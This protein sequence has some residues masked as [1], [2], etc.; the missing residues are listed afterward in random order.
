MIHPIILSGGS[1]TRLWPASRK[2]YPKQFAPL[3]G[4]ESLYQITLR[5]LSGPEFAR[6]VVMTNVE[7]R[8]LASQQAHEIGLSDAH[9]AIEPA[10]RDTAPAILAAALIVEQQSGR[11][12]TALVAPSDH[13]IGDVAAFNAAVEKGRDAAAE[14][15][16]VTFGVTPD[17]PETGYGYLE[18]AA[19][20]GPS[21]IAVPLSAFREK[22]DAETAAKMIA[23]GNCLWNSGMFLFRV[24][25]VLDAF[26]AYAPDL[27][28]PVRAAV[29]GG[30]EDLSF[31][32]LAEAPFAEARD[33]AFDVAIMEKA[34]TA[35]AVPLSSAWS[36]LGAWDAL[37]TS[38]EHD[39]AGNATLGPTT[40]LDCERSYLRSEESNVH[41]VGLGL[42]DTIV[43]AMRDA[44]LVADRH[45]AQDV[46]SAVAALRQSGVGQADDYPRFHRP[47]GWYETLCI[48][49]RFQVK[50]IMVRPGGVLSLQSHMHR[51]EHWVVV[52]GTAEVTIGEEKKLLT[53]NQSVYIPLGA[54]HRMSNPGRLPMY[55]IEVQTGAYLGEDDII[56]YE[57]DY[58]RG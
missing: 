11:E 4:D 56:R 32:R 7:F 48:D 33:I 20:P 35:V 27:L 37:W 52:A 51:S 6:P 41:V 13:V 42:R 55:L 22:P 9:V 10:G 54:V 17:R 16:L 18:L 30:H 38:A 34:E 44:V 57:D 36:D 2:A 15:K 23:A 1:G 29:T 28:A 21:G 45:R 47:W 25:D 31:F 58:G 5:R 3:L 39:A 24:G 50:R 46:K 53:E 8:F 26:E 40:A 12:A 49:S 19:S 14:G 43:V